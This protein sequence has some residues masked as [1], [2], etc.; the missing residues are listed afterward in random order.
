ME[1]PLVD[2]DP[3]ASM[4]DLETRINELT[5][6]LSWAYRYNVH[7]AG[8][9]QMALDSYRARYNQKQEE[10]YKK[11]QQNSDGTYFDKINIS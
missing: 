10:I 11:A 1:H 9:V 4:E 6:K 2:I 5:K 8:Q 7:L 3:T